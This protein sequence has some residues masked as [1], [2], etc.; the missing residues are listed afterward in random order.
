M[1]RE[2]GLRADGIDL[3]KN[4]LA[5]ARRK[6][7]SNGLA[8][9][10]DLRWGDCLELD[11]PGRYDGIYSRDV[12]LHIADKQRLFR[13]LFRA[14]RPGGQLLFSDYCCGPEPWSEAFASYVDSRGYSLLTTAQY[15]ELLAGAGFEKVRARDETARFIEL[16]RTEQE[17]IDSLPIDAD[18]R[19]GLRQSWQQKVERARAGDQRWGVFRA[20]KPGQDADRGE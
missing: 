14:L 6:L 8:G 7:D 18:E 4:M 1:A 13:V 9:R 10:V 2:F 12:F 20:V 17:R 16:L 11:C 15:A 5:L 3:S 19:A